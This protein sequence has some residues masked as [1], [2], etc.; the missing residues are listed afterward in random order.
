MCLALYDP[1]EGIHS[2]KWIKLVSRTR[3]NGANANWSAEL[4]GARG[5]RPEGI[6][7]RL[8][9][10]KLSILKKMIYLSTNC[11]RRLSSA[12]L[13]HTDGVTFEPFKNDA[14]SP[15]KR[16]ER[17]F[18]SSLDTNSFFIPAWTMKLTNMRLCTRRTK[19][20]RTISLDELPK[21]HPLWERDMA[22]RQKN[23]SRV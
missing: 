8:M 7:D 13:P 22:K 12:F 17:R 20:R 18:F 11:L 2:S 10:C 16:L 9:L 1:C 3:K 14:I 15:R 23:S 19:M 4:L 21:S 5:L 6:F